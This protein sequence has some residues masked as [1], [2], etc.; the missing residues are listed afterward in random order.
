[1]MTFIFW[2]LLWVG[3]GHVAA[4]YAV[5][6]VT[7]VPEGELIVIVGLCWFC[8]PVSLAC[9]LVYFLARLVVKK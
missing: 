7:D 8:G 5:R 1:M 9:L 3:C 6:K 2:L 4:R